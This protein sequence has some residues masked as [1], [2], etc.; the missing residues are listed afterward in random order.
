MALWM[1]LFTPLACAEEACA[2]RAARLL[3]Q[4]MSDEL[5]TWF[6]AST[7]GT[8][9]ALAQFSDL[10][11]SLEQITAVDRTRTG[12]FYRRSITSGD[13]PS[14]YD[15]WG[16]WAEATSHK[17]GQV[18]IQASVEVGSDCRLLALHLDQ[19]CD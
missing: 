16:T 9:R 6:V 17:L 3:S 12:K 10:L 11:G 5:A 19:Y 2:V 1:A 8:A 14:S 7:P 18:R 13:L 15:Y 4:G